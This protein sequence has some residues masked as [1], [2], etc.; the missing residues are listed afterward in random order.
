[1]SCKYFSKMMS[2]F[3]EQCK[4]PHTKISREKKNCQFTIARTLRKYS[5]VIKSRR[6]K[7]CFQAKYYVVY[8]QEV[9]PQH[10]HAK[11]SGNVGRGTNFFVNPRSITS[12][13]GTR[14]STYR[15]NQFFLK[16]VTFLV[17]VVLYWAIISFT[18]PANTTDNQIHYQQFFLEGVLVPIFIYLIYLSNYHLKRQV[19]QQHWYQNPSFKQQQASK[20]IGFFQ[21]S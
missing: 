8:Q 6:K 2:F 5:R 18:T 9:D 10:L 15:V 1:M 20:A 13:D 11:L 21:T 3:S 16:Q 14:S 17:E 12:Q 4:K 7:A 19:N